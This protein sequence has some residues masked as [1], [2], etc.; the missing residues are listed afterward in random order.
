MDVF[1]ITGF[2][3]DIFLQYVQSNVMDIGLNSYFKVHGKLESM[4]IAGGLMAGLILPFQIFKIPITLTTMAIYGTGL[5]FIFRYA[6]IMPSLD[7]YYKHN[8]IA[9]T[10]IIG[11]AIPMMLPLIISMLNNYSLL[12]YS[13]C[14]IFSPCKYQYML[15]WIPLLLYTITAGPPTRC[16]SPNK[17]QCSYT[18]K[19]LLITAGP[20]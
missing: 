3:G 2:F 17:Y 15:I 12:L 16:F 1:F 19:P 18:Y 7:E 10:S 4:L 5:D 6:R 20:S 11:G 8:G 13:S 14:D 9:V